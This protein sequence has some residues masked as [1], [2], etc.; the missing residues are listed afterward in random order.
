M[1]CMIFHMLRCKHLHDRYDKS[2]FFFSDFY[3]LLSCFRGIS[4][5][6]ILLQV[7]WQIFFLLIIFRMDLS[8]ATHGL[9]C[10]NAHLHKNF[11]TYPKMMKLCT[12]IPYLTKIQNIHKSR[13]TPIKFCWNVV[14]WPK[15]GNSNILYERSYHN[16][17]F[18]RIW[19]E[20]TIFL[21]VAVGSSSIIWD[22]Q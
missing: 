17:S 20:K 19:P 18:I 5:N 8:G 2:D 4:A 3:S 15:F 6:K 10:K 14:M 9:G 16:L 11:R 13:E 1:F 22:W 21:R 12:V 7:P